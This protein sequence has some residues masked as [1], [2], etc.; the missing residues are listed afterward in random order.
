MSMWSNMNF[1]ENLIWNLEHSTA[2]K[3]KFSIKDFF[4]KYDQIRSFLRIWRHLLKKSLMENFIF[5]AVGE[6]KKTKQ[7]EQKNSLW[8]EKLL[9]VLGKVRGNERK[10]FKR[11]QNLFHIVKNSRYEIQSVISLIK[12][13]FTKVWRNSFENEQTKFELLNIQDSKCQLL[14]HK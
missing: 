12:C 5:Y 1:K 2:Q 7:W 11:Q 8:Q 3:T 13:Q 6:I 4:S 10:L 9:N 14:L